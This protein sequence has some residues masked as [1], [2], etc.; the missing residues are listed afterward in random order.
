MQRTKK[1]MSLVMV[2]LVAFAAFAPMAHAY[3][4]PFVDNVE[5]YGRGKVI[6]TIHVCGNEKTYQFKVTNTKT[7]KPVKTKAYMCHEC[8]RKHVITAVM[9]RNTT[10]TIKVRTKVHGK[11]TKW[12]AIDYRIR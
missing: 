4:Y 6:T 10:Y 12:R 9:K 8:N 11:W 1:I 5:D 7:H 2:A 3:S